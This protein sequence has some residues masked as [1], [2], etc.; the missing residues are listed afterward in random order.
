MTIDKEFYSQNADQKERGTETDSL[1]ITGEPATGNFFESYLHLAA[2]FDCFTLF[3]NGA[4]TAIQFNGVYIVRVYPKNTPSGIFS[5]RYLERDF[6]HTPLMDRAR[7]SG[8]KLKNTISN[9]ADLDLAE[10]MLS[11]KAGVVC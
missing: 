9:A 3:E 1:D 10:Q 4:Y 7:L 2:S 5:I 8:G 11:D 6:R